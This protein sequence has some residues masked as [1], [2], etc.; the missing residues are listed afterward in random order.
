MKM[1]KILLACLLSTGWTQAQN[2]TFKDP[3]FKNVLLNIKILQADDNNYDNIYLEDLNGNKVTIDQ[4]NDNEI[5]VQ[6]ALNV[7]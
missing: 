3:E 1:K 2:I 5:S 7:G 6:E 4:N